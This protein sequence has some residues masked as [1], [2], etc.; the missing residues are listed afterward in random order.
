MWRSVEEHLANA[1]IARI[2]YGAIIGLALVVTLEHHPPEPGLVAASLVA[3]GLAVAF[4][5]L[6]SDFIG[7]QTRTRRSVERHHFRHMIADA[8][9][10][11]GGIVFPAVFFL[12]AGLG[13]IES[14]S[15]YTAAKWSGLGLIAF[16]GFCAGRLS[17]Y[18]FFTALMHSLAVTAIGGA[19]IGFKALVH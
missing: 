6:Y 2:L 10:V 19:L 8:L 3:T 13:V 4:A 12:L 11:F 15:A 14:H 16:Y 17:G 7:T 9:A 18:S 5:E 1:Q